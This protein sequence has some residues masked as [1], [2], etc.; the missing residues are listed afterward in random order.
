MVDLALAF[1]LVFV[2]P[3]IQIWKSVRKSEQPA[4]TRMQRYIH[5]MR[6]IVL[7]LAAL[8]FACWWHGHTPTELG[9]DMPTSGLALWCLIGAALALPAMHFWGV[10]QSSKM[11]PARRAAIEEKMR[12]NQSMPRTRE[13]LR[14]FLILSLFIGFGWEVLYRGFVTLALAPLIGTWG[15]VAVAAAA[16][17]AGHGYHGPRHLLS[18]IGMALL[19]TVAYLLTDSLWWLIVVHVGLPVMGA[20]SYY[21]I[22]RQIPAKPQ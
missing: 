4:R 20:I 3:G 2:L 7:L 22:L 8:V 15:A 16:Y 6:M 14:V 5:S 19:F 9:L 18:S 17:G 11:E 12:G 10:L 13:E 1:Y 21:K